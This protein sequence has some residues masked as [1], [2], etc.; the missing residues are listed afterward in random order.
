[1]PASNPAAPRV[2]PGKR[3]DAP[4]FQP[5]PGAAETPSVTELADRPPVATAAP[6]L[7][8]PRQ[9]LDAALRPR[10]TRD[11][12]GAG[13]RTP[14][15]A[16]WCYR[17]RRAVVALWL[18]ALALVTLTVTLTGTAYD[19]TFSPPHSQSTQATA[20]L[21]AAQPSAAGDQDEIVLSVGSG[22]ITDPAVK[23]AVAQMLGQIGRL[24]HVASVETPYF[25]GHVAPSG[26]V[27]FATVSFDVDSR[28]VT[29]VEAAAVVATATRI[30]TGNLRVSLAG[31]VIEKTDHTP[32]GG[33]GLGVA[34]AGVVLL[35]AFGS[36]FAAALPLLTALVSLGTGIG[37]VALTSHVLPSASFSAQ[38]ASL[39]G[40]GVGVDYALFIVTRHRQALSRGQEPRGRGRGGRRHGRSRGHLRRPHGLCGTAWDVCAAHQIPLRRGR[41]VAASPSR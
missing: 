8:R 2:R 38:L 15:L 26:R 25:A 35:V 32:S 27:A 10:S 39:V 16:R 19:D 4:V 1:M 36:L 30:Q 13:D 20:L 11:A 31:D 34:L 21:K 33:I 9:A 23:T 24:A 18:A 5:T 41:C 29:N 3:V 6:V 12:G 14:R 7:P 40:L 17:H 37:L 28:D 22:S